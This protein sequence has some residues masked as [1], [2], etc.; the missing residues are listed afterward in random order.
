SFPVLRAIKCV[1]FY[2]TASTRIRILSVSGGVRSRRDAGTAGVSRPGP[3]VLG[4]GSQ[5]WSKSDET[6]PATCPEPGTGPQVSSIQTWPRTARAWEL[7]A[8]VR[9]RTQRRSPGRG[10]ARIRNRVGAKV[11]ERTQRRGPGPT[12]DGIR[13][14]RKAERRE[15]TQ[16]RR[17]L[18]A[19]RIG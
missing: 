2:A 12:G 5:A 9:D 1:N 17:R 4:S 11:R 7:G 8:K 14:T 3:R 15:R 16:F 19:L 6:N 13:S 10:R 18:E